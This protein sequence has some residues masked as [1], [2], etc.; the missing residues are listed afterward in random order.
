[1]DHPF[2]MYI[3]QSPGDAFELLGA[4]SSVTGGTSGG[5][6]ALRARTGLYSY[7]P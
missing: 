3:Q 2:A 6:E 1:M 4:I 7:M 5:S